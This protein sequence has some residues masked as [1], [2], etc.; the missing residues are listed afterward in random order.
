FHLQLVLTLYLK[1]A[2]DAT[3][4]EP[5]NPS[6]FDGPPDG[7][8]ADTKPQGR[9]GPD[10]TNDT[11]AILMAAI[12]PLLPNHLAPK[13]ASASSSTATAPS[14]STTLSCKAAVMA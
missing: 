13:P 1:A 8:I 9:T 4:H 6:D 2:G 11:T 14:L 12:L 5:P 3:K 7:H 10:P